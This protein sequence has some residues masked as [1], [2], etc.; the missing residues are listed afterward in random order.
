MIPSSCR[1]ASCRSQRKKIK[2][3]RR[4]LNASASLAR[5]TANMQ[6]RQAS[7][8]TAAR[9]ERGT[10]HSSSSSS[11]LSSGKI[12]NRK[13]AKKH[14]WSKRHSADDWVFSAVRADRSHL[15]IQRVRRTTVERSPSRLATSLVWSLLSC[16]GV[17]PSIRNPVTAVASRRR[18]SGSDSPK[19]M[20]T[21]VHRQPQAHTHDRLAL[22]AARS[23]L[24]SATD[25]R[26]RTQR[27]AKR[28]EAISH[29]R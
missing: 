12:I 3:H 18:R 7:R 22:L 5:A 19:Q 20:D 13:K 25:T 28:R 2:R 24:R 14:Q 16:R 11:S 10:T 15:R 21:C 26:K 29:R 1:L 4:A 9:R 17:C 23:S 27:N 6:R 8:S